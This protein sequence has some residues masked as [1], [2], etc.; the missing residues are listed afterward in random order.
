M[1]NVSLLS[2][3]IMLLRILQV[4]YSIEV[5]KTLRHV[6]TA[7]CCL[8]MIDMAGRRPD[9]PPQADEYNWQARNT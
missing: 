9:G 5:F 1:R 6:Q 2:K 4:F 8:L 7:V 3:F